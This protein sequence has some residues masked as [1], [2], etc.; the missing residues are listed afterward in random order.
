[1][2]ELLF[3]R[4]IAAFCISV[5]D[6]EEAMEFAFEPWMN[7]YEGRTKDLKELIRTVYSKGVEAVVDMPHSV[8]FD[9]FLEEW[10]HAK[11]CK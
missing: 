11:V 7:L 3:V 2:L 4:I 10:P 5:Y 6:I 9:L 1:M 8:F